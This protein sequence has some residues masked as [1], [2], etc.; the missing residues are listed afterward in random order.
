MEEKLRGL[1][2]VR[3]SK[4][5]LLEKLRANRE[6]HTSIYKEA[7]DKW[8]EQIVDVLK[9]ELK[10][11]EEDKGYYPTIYVPQP[12]NHTKDYDRTIAQLE[13]SL[14]SEFLLSSSEFAKY[15]QDEW[16][17]K[18][19]FTTTVSGCLNYKNNI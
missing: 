3:V 17:W 9:E 7:F 2:S 18:D 1:G 5:F 11:V 14:D 12:S 13:A 4:D 6:S 19:S 16:D 8:H 15:V 10:K